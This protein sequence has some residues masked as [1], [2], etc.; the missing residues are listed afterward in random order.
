MKKQLKSIAALCCAAILTAGCGLLNLPTATDQ[1]GNPTGTTA[2]NIINIIGSI[3]GSFGN[4]TDQASILGTWTYQEPAV[5]F[6]SDNLLAKAGGSIASAKVVEQLAPYYEKAGIKPGKMILT[7]NEDKTCSLAIGKK[8]Y[9]GTYEFNE[10][11]GTMD[12]KTAAFNLP[13]AY[14]SVSGS[15]FALTFDS[16]KL[17]GMVQSAGKVTGSDST[18]SQIA[19]IAQAYDGMKTGFLFTK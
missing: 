7:L 1:D 11:A 5:Q 10:E 14:V 3:L 18:L 2:E 15:Q 16:T 4:T 8:T 12:I 19:S 9:S 13:T 6:T 17:L